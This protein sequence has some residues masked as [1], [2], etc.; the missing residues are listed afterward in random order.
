MRAFVAFLVTAIVFV[1]AQGT[2][3]P[4]LFHL[5]YILAGALVTSYLWAWI[6]LRGLSAQRDLRN[7]RAQVG[8]QIEEHLI[9]RNKSIWPKLWVEVEELSDLPEHNARIVTGITPN[10]F[11]HLRV[12]TVCQ[13]RGKYTLGPIIIRTS[14]PLELFHFQKRI[15]TMADVLIYPATEPIHGFPLPPAELPG[16]TATRR[17]TYHTTSNVSGVRDYAPGDSLNRIHWPSTARQRRLIV[18][19]FELDPTADLWIVLDMYRRVQQSI[20]WRGKPDEEPTHE[21]RTP[22]STEEYIVTAAASLASHFILNQRRNTGLIGW[23]QHR[24]IIPPDREPR[25]FYS[26]LESLAILRAYGSSPLPEV[27]AAEA[28]R[29]SRQTSVVI[30]TCSPDPGWVRS[31]L[32]QLLYSGIFAV[33]VLVDGTTFG[34]WHETTRVEAELIANNVPYYILRNGQPIGPSLSGAASAASSLD[35]VGARQMAEHYQR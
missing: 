20:T 9:V 32:R 34:G 6:N 15:H 22:A 10:V 25:Q 1:M 2:G 16:G 30:L 27:L 28:N 12:R 3:N 24:E 14:D 7:N 5:F 29:F 18:K 19:E 11:R 31:G 4:V 23:G 21:I 26:I 17:R 13:L 35:W 8:R 33:V